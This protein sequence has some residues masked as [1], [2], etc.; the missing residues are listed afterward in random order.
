MAGDVGWYTSS[1]A[2]RVVS[3]RTV[4]L[5]PG[6]YKLLYTVL[7]VLFVFL[8]FP[9]EIFSPS[10][11]STGYMVSGTRANVRSS[12]YIVWFLINSVICN[13]SCDAVLY[14]TEYI[15]FVTLVRLSYAWGMFRC[16]S[17]RMVS[18]LRG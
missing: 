4:V 2:C 17:P 16:A 9:T 12:S 6:V 3:L 5:V 13:L 18:P 11:V 14:F 15:I 7:G 1:A 8:F 10:F